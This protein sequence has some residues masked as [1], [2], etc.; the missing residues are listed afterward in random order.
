M[1]ARGLAVGASPV[2]PVR[3]LGTSHTPLTR[4]R[5][6]QYAASDNILPR[7]PVRLSSVA[8]AM[9][10]GDRRS[11]GAGTVDAHR[12]GGISHVLVVSGLHL[13]LLCGGLFGLLFALTR[14]RRL[15]AALCIAFT[16]FFMGFC[17]LSAPVV[18]SGVVWL[19][20]YLGQAAGRR[21]DIFTSMGLAALLLA[22]QNP[23]AA[24]DAGLLLSFSATLGAVGSEPAFEWLW[25]RVARRQANPGACRWLRGIGRRSLRLAVT[26]A[27]T[28]LATLPVLMYA[29]MGF[30]VFAL[31]MNL[32]AVPLL[33]VI[34]VCGLL[35]ALPAVPV[36]GW[37]A[38]AAS[39]VN[40][41]ALRLIEWLAELCGRVWW[42]WIPVGGAFALVT[43]LA[44]Y[45]LAL[46]ALAVGLHLALDSGT[47]RV[48][49]AGGG[50]NA[51][52]VAASGGRAVVLY[53]GGM[54]AGAV[55]RILRESRVR[56]CVL[57]V[58]MR[59]TAEGTE[60]AGRFAP[61]QVVSVNDDLVSGGVYTP[62]DNVAVYVARQGG[63]TVA[64][65][66]VAGYKVGLTS[67]S[68][69]LSPY[70]PLDVLVAG[71]GTVSGSYGTL[72]C[73]AAVPEWA[74]P[75]GGILHSDGDAQ[76]WLRPGRS[77]V[78]REING[79]DDGG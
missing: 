8:A 29:G 3:R 58:D 31:P 9:A 20:Y 57:L 56:E 52:L 61:A 40:G 16:L 33:P 45:A 41:V 51:S 6:L 7:L 4:L 25:V 27:C 69:D 54:S 63:G 26:S 50:Q 67:G 12:A 42:A 75:R 30:S 28:T 24:A 13:S 17:G 5:Q 15:S 38:P 74:A 46:L 11:L 44:L 64:C 65:V 37:L 59:R 49:V 1:A 48:T 62:L 39:L 32:V 34:V 73:G 55:Q 21:S 79:V 78:F 68:V 18:R 14:R 60:Y 19:L 71:T 76:L 70:A 72:L 23:Y 43:V 10:V 53:R 35:M 77:V 2:G 36:L 47:V 66:E 22:G